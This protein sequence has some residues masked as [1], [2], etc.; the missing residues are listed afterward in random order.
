[1]DEKNISFVCG[2]NKFNFRVAILIKNKN[3]VL[4]ERCENFWNMIGGRVHFGE[5]TLEAAHR[6]LKEELGV[7]AE[8][9]TL[10]NVSETFFDWLGKKQQELLFVYYAEI[11]DEFEITSKNNF[12]C[13]DSDEIFAWHEISEVKNLVC[14]PE[15]IKILVCETGTNLT[16]I[17]KKDM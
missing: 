13:L 8:N 14:K 3:R 4:L 15:I 1:M 11:G 16:H 6:E 12:K 10:I 5:S 2:E 7:D 17:I 9:L